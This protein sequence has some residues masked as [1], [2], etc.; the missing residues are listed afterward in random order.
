MTKTLILSALA[1]LTTTAAFA[2][3]THAGGH[4]Q[5]MVGVPGNASEISRTIKVKMAETDDG[6]MIFKP[7]VIDVERG[8]TIRF[9]I[10]NSG[11]LDHEFVVDGRER[12]QEHKALMAKF[13]EME[14]D[15][16]NAIRLA[17]GASG[18]ILWNFVNDGHFEFACLIPGHYESGMRGDLNVV[19][20]MA[21]N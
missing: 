5:M 15:D 21:R 20:T 2:E 4:D 8:E 6:E 1:L 10:I 17:P 14:H 13:P 3:G 19:E 12:N 16:P 7:S 9:I 11:E 18:E